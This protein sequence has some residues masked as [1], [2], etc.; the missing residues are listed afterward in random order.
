MFKR[1]ATVGSITLL[2]VP[3]AG[4]G[5]TSSGAHYSRP[6]LVA[7]LHQQGVPTRDISHPATAFDRQVATFLKPIDPNFV[8]AKFQSGEFVGIAFTAD[9]A[10]ASNVRRELQKLA[11]SPGATPGKITQKGSI[12][13]LTYPHV[14][15]GVQ[16]TLDQCE[17]NAATS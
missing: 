8:G 3:A 14:T 7:C 4:C 16:K 10:G 2:A 11:T 6:A 5:G 9:S 17:S 1:L 12:V 13:V 15:A